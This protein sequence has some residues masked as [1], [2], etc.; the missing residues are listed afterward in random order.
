MCNPSWTIT[1][2]QS[3]L[4]YTNKTSNSFKAK[5]TKNTGTQARIGTLQVTSGSTIIGT[6]TVTQSGTAPVLNTSVSE[7][8]LRYNETEPIIV[9]YN[10]NLAIWTFRFRLQVTGLQ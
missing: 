8:V 5:V 6:V 1:S 4:S 3:W 9:S 10:S 7:V 2:N